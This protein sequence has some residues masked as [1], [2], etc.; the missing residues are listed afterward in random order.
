LK[1]ILLYTFLSDIAN[2]WNQLF[3]ALF[4]GVK[5]DMACEN[6]NNYA[7]GSIQELV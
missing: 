5:S 2:H 1:S 7:G 3:D 4:P 6:T